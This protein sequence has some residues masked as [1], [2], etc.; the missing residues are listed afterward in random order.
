MM[1]I[2]HALSAR[3]LFFPRIGSSL[4]QQ[5]LRVQQYINKAVRVYEYYLILQSIIEIIHDLPTSYV[6]AVNGGNFGYCERQ[7]IYC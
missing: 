4:H 5:T 6:V 7:L 2:S 1:L 3:V